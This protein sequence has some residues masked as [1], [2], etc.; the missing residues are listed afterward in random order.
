MEFHSGDGSDDDDVVDEDGD[1]VK[2]SFCP[3][4]FASAEARSSHETD[5]H[6]MECQGY[7]HQC[8]CRLPSKAALVFHL[9]TGHPNVQLVHPSPMQ[10]YHKAAP[11]EIVVASVPAPDI[12]E[13]PQLIPGHNIK[14]SSV[15]LAFN[16]EE[17]I[18][19]SLGQDTTGDIVIEM[20]GQEEAPKRSRASKSVFECTECAFTSVSKV[21]AGLFF[22]NFHLF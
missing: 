14:D 5:F 17:P 15:F 13:P 6:P 8:S 19:F 10:P 18:T 11:A 22:R 20:P 2:C 12:P 1:E 21:K 9:K 16:K 7:C 3:R 4:S